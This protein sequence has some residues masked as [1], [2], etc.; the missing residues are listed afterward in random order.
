M[1]VVAISRTAIEGTAAVLMSFVLFGGSVWLL[2]AA[3]FG[4]RMGYLVAATGMFAFMI[5]LSALWTFGAPG[6]PAFLGP[7]GDLPAWIAAG[8]GTSLRSEDFPVIQKYPGKPW[9]DPGAELSAE[10]EGATVPIQEFLATRASGQLRRAGIEGEVTPEDF[11][12]TD[13]KFTESDGTLLGAARVFATAGGPEITV[14]AF[15][16]K[17]D[18]PLPSYLFLGGSIIGFAAHLPFLDRAER[19]RKEILTGGDQA[20]WRGPA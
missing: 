13:L 3:I 8:A 2:L 14:V 15:K 18:E 12:V 16:S 9:R 11:E 20:P 7:K 6:T 17:G 4:V 5:V 19:K 1:E 10:V